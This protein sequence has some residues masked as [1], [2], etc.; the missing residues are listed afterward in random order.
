MQATQD[1]HHPSVEEDD[2]FISSAR[3]G[4]RAVFQQALVG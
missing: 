3:D 1:R 4:V 2:T